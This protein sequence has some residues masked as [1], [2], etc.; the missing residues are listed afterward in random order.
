MV[1]MFVDGEDGCGQN[2]CEVSARI[3][4][5]QPRLRVNV[6][7]I[8]ESKFSNCI[9]ENTGGRV[10]AAREVGEVQKMLREAMEEV[11][12]TPTCAGAQVTGK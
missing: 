3:A 6:V 5:E 4:R 8:S 11:A 10:Y 12:T 1:V 2:A 7:N 9:A